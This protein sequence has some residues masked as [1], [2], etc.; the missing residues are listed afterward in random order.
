MQSD[1]MPHRVIFIHQNLPGQFKHLLAYCAQNACFE[2]VVV[3][4]KKRLLVNFRRAVPN[5]TFYGYDVDEISRSQ[6]PVE[7]WT[8]TNAMRRGRAVALCL[9]R[10]KDSGFVPDAIY[11][12]PG[13][14]E[15]LHVRDVF[16]RARVLNY[17]EFYFNRDG[18]DVGFD[19][20]FQRSETDDFR[21]RTDN[22]TQLVSLVE[23]DGGISPT[24]W[25][26][27]RYPQLLQSSISVVHDGIDLDTVTP[28]PS[29]AIT[30]G[31]TSI[32]LDRSVPVITFVSRN[33]EPY[34]GFHIFMRSLPSILKN[35]PNAHVLIV[36]GDDVSYSRKLA[37]GWT[38][39]TLM[40]NELSHR[41]DLSRVH[42]LGRISYGQYLNVLR[43]STAHVYLTYPFVLSWSML[44]AMATGAVVVGSRTAPVEEVIKHGANGVLVDFFSP[45]EIAEAVSDI[46]HRREDF[47]EM[48]FAARKTIEVAFD[49]RRNCLQEQLRLLCPD[50]DYSQADAQVESA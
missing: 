22:M 10:I 42:F 1:V 6:V 35:V 7:L 27:S 41:I 38:Y 50:H 2:V 45:S 31:Q 36:G 14:G 15:M 25:Q 33:L 48:R 43:L 8:T 46:C 4:E 24:Q 21:V 47:T 49:L 40:L 28:D 3:G 11:G 29:A 32:R 37:D 26:R 9:N 13:W 44:E 17:C 5:V 20:E 34:R 16:P 30:L 12:H 19:S 39:R 23:A 18:Q